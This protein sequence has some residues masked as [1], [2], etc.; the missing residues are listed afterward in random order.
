MLKVTVEVHPFGSAPDAYKVLEA[1]IWNAGHNRLDPFTYDYGYTISGPSWRGVSP[2]A[3]GE[4]KGYDRNQPLSDLLHIVFAKPEDRLMK[5][6]SAEMRSR[7]EMHAENGKAGW[8]GCDIEY[9]W[10][11]LDKN[12][13]Q[14]DPIDVGVLAWMIYERTK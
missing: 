10:E 12:A 5:H 13:Q 4:V 2:A 1:D 7:F 9:L 11:L 3:Q 8:E 14:L 6:F